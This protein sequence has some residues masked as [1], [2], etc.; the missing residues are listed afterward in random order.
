MTSEVGFSI[1]NTYALAFARAHV[2]GDTG[3]TTLAILD[4]TAQVA[5]EATLMRKGP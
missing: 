4:G 2:L 3:E 5:A 1:V